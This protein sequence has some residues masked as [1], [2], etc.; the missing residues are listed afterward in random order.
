MQPRYCCHCQIMSIKA[1]QL[2]IYTH[3]DISN[4]NH[5]AVHLKLNN[6][7]NQPY[8][9]LKINLADYISVPWRSILEITVESSLM[10]YSINNCLEGVEDDVCVGK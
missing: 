3:I 2:S 4:Q 7:L 8:Y 5:F 6:I 1:C 10:Q 9:N